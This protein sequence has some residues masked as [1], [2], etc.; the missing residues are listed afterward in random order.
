MAHPHIPDAV[1]PVTSKDIIKPAEGRSPSTI[2]VMSI[3][4]G[5]AVP[6]L[7]STSYSLRVK[8]TIAAKDNIII[9][10]TF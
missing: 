7:S 3:P 1:P 4:L 5:V 9:Q 6:V 10:M 8:K 2:T